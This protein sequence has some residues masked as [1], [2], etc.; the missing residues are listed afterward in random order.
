MRKVVTRIAP[1]P[2]GWMHLGTARTAIFAYLYAKRHGGEFKIRI[3]DT[4]KARSA[5]E[6]QNDILD[7]LDW[8]GLDYDG[9]IVFQSERID[10]HR[11]VI[12]SCLDAKVAYKCYLTAEEA[13]GLKV[14]GKAFR[15]PYR[16]SDVVEDRP[17]T[18]R[19]KVPD[20]QI[21]VEDIVRGTVHFDSNTLDDLV[22]LRSDGNPTYNLVVAVDDHDMGVTHVIRG[23]DHLAN[24][25]KQQLIYEAMGWEVP[26]W[27]HLPL[28]HNEKGQ[29]MS[30]RHGDAAN[31]SD[32][33][34]DGYPADGVFN[35]L[36]RLG[37]GKD[38]MELFTREEVQEV[39]DLS[40]IVK[41]P[42]RFD[43][44][45]LR[46]TCEWHFRRLPKDDVINYA[47]A[48][49]PDL[50]R[51]AVET[52]YDCYASEASATLDEFS[53]SVAN[54]ACLTGPTLNAPPTK[55][56]EFTYQE[57]LDIC[58]SIPK[59]IKDP[60][61]VTTYIRDI[62]KNKNVSMG[63]FGQAFRAYFYGGL[64]SPDFGS[65]ILTIREQHPTI[66]VSTTD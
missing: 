17:Y 43:S 40:N 53:K 1:S 52:A 5:I 20:T 37:W 47:I 12:D 24:T 63:A 49:Y 13:A 28:I 16:D 48:K 4:D 54:T 46:N 9:D 65:C 7:G 27:A 15:S 38:T 62:L 57:I 22:L 41:S 29:K 60:K 33:A 3:E 56:V 2:T 23:D 35:Y 11:E 64:P 18:V 39:F 66:F 10:R 34:A 8:L 61:A 59:N 51:S 36:C 26:S 58:G 6:Y 14:Q 19:F 30:K 50:V 42:A 25:P 44:K 45:K 32:L 31:L 21:V 55:N